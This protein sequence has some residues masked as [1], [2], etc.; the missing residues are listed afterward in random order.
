MGSHRTQAGFV[1][2]RRDAPVDEWLAGLREAL[3]EEGETWCGL[4]T[5]PNGAGVW[6]RVLAPGAAQSNAL[7]AKAWSRAREMI[8]GSVPSARRK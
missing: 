4:S 5:L 3:R 7:L 8:T 2:A 1:V 6:V